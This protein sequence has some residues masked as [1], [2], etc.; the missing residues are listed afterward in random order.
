MRT[1]IP[2]MSLANLSL[3]PCS[4]SRMS[5]KNLCRKMLCL[6]VALALLP[7]AGCVGS[8]QGEDQKRADAN[9]A[10]GK[11]GKAAHAAA[12]QSGKAASAVGKDLSKM[13]RQAHAGWQDAAQQEK[14]K[15]R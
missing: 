8:G 5:V 10:A 4:P 3:S 7:L 15:K 9:S 1:P 12:V 6:P 2:E 11:V 13:A 14:A